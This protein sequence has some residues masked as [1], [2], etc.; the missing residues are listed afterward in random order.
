MR[1][2]VVVPTYQEAL[3]VTTVLTGVREAVPAADV[4][5]VDDNSP[6]GTAELAEQVGAGV[7]QVHVLRRPQRN[8]LGRAYRAAWEW[9]LE[10]GSH[11][12]A[13]LP[14]LLGPLADGADLV[15]GSRYVPGGSV[16]G[17]D[18]HRRLLSQGGNRYAGA[19]LGLSVH[20]A[21]GGFRAYRADLLRRIDLSTL[22]AD[23]Y[24]FQVELVYRS[25]A[26]GAKI[27]EVPIT[28]V[29]RTLGTSKMSLAIVWE[30]LALVS[31][32]AAR[33]RLRGA[34]AT[35]ST[36]WARRQRR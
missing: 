36:A 2:V 11:D 5:V 6:D 15:L 20:D 24:G 14:S 4:L 26:L 23:G 30:A 21:T 10:R 1:T 29:D 13:A 3:N 22:A 19:L 25:A 28:F 35:T 18:L 27:V 17:W 32:W 34:A 33:D 9:A 8:G 12:P 7:G 16:P 31:W